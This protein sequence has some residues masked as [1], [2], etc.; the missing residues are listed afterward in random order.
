VN[1]RG[2]TSTLAVQ[3]AVRAVLPKESWSALEPPERNVPAVL[4]EVLGRQG[5]EA[6]FD[7]FVSSIESQ[8]ADILIRRPD[9]SYRP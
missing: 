4:E 2:H 8:R 7:L 3:I 5:S 6:L 1:R 9:L